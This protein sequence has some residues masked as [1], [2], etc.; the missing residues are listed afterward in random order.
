MHL[1]IFIQQA[2]PPPRK[3]NTVRGRR[4]VRNTIFVPSGSTPESLAAMPDPST[5]PSPPLGHRKSTDERP[6]DTQSIRSAHS[7][8]S[9][10]PGAT[11]RHPEMV[12]PGLNVSIIETVSTTLREGQITQALVTGEMAM[13]YNGQGNTAKEIVRLDN[14]AV[15]HKV[16]PNPQFVVSVPER[17]GEYHLDLQAIPRSQV[18]FKYQV[19]LEE[20]A[21]GSHSPLLLSPVWKIEPHQA[22]VI[23]NYKFNP[24][25]IA[26]VEK[27]MLSN[28]VIVLHI[29]NAKAIS[30]MSKPVGTFSKER[31][32]IY[33]RLGEVVIEKN[34][35][36][37]RVLARFVTDGEAKAG[38]VEARWEVNPD[39]ASGLGSDLGLS[40]KADSSGKRDTTPDPF[41]DELPMTD[42][43]ASYKPVAVVRKLVS[44]KYIVS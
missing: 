23:V 22:S 43:V 13:V 16:A 32:Q 10:A 40:I 2:G 18:G 6:S 1:L 27:I 17:T 8:N 24:A 41:S 39:Q 25:L 21:L 38:T 5:F 28:V 20:N 29:E 36:E 42:I 9:L 19:H 3:Q 26:N 31:S 30:C 33:W 15:L 35:A 44:G 34:A 12:H 4:D 14:F 11:H 7:L 37:Q